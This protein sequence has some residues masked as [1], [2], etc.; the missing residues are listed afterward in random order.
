MADVL[1]APDRVIVFTG[2]TGASDAVT[3]PARGAD[4]LV[5]E[6]ASFEDRMQLM[7]RT[8]QWQAMTPA[9]QVATR[10][11]ALQGH[12]HGNRW[13]DGSSRQGQDRDPHAPNLQARWRLQFTSRR[14]ERILF[15]RGAG[16]EGPD[17]ILT[18]SVAP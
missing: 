16:R 13:T 11:Q 5:T 3:E 4:L 15:G 18:R 12:I 6:T 9:Q 17:G 2:D 7:I 8:G 10:N 14:S 1:S